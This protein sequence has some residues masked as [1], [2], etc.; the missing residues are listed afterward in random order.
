[1]VQILYT[2]NTILK[3][4]NKIFVTFQYCIQTHLDRANINI[5]IY[6]VDVN[7]RICFDYSKA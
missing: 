5:Y 3:V 2:E 4:S 7:I 6:S 1:M